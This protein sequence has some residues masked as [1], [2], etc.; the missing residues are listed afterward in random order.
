[1]CPGGGGGSSE[2][3]VTSVTD[4]TFYHNLLF[5]LVFLFVTSDAYVNFKECY[6]P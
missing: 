2:T 4:V 3:R 5:L 6:E 1:M